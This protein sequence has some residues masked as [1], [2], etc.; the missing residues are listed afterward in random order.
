M[1]KLSEM[2][3]I[4]K[5]RDWKIETYATHSDWGRIRKT[6]TYQ[7]VDEN[8]KPITKWHYT[9]ITAVRNALR[10]LQNESNG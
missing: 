4:L 9:K 7:V 5:M 3:P 8:Y 6:Y 10:S 2:M 1:K